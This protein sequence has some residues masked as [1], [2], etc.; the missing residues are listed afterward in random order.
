MSIKNKYRVQSVNISTVKEWFL[1]KHYAK[2]LPMCS[3][4]FSLLNEKNLVVGVCTFGQTPSIQLN[5]SLSDNKFNVL[6]LNRL[7]T[8]DDLDKNATSYFVGKCLKLL[9]KPLIIVSF[10]DTTKNHHGYIYQATNWIY[11][12]LNAERYE[13]KSK[14]KPNLHYR[15]IAERYIGI[16]K[17]EVE[18]L[19]KQQ[20]SRK[21]RYVYF[22]G[23]RKQN[24]EM[25][26]GLK[27][28]IENYPKGDN[29]NYDASYQPSVQ[30]TMF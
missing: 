12:G 9:P 30:T 14:S 17:N 16:D 6:E 19:Y 26:N 13:W 11:T 8:N 21:H 4:C 28:N 24:K 2:R 18:D 5:Y 7:I 27:Y 25:L 23:N 3:Y 22:L 20:L 29:K 1:K 10:A 15:N